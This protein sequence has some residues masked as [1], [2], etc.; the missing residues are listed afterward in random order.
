MKPNYTLITYQ[1][2]P[3]IKVS[4]EYNAAWN[5]K[6]QAVAGAKWSKTLNSWHI[7][8]T[9]EN[10]KKCGLT[11][12][13]SITII[14][15]QPGIKTSGTALSSISTNNKKQLEKFLQQ[16]ALKAYSPSTVRTYRN[17]FGTFLQTLGKHAAEK[18]TVQ[19]IKD[20]LQY[21]HTQLKLSENSIH[22]RMNAFYPVGLKK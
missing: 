16:L 14:K 4:F 13:N 22:S 15:Q 11:E 6:M 18:L 3:R 2:K 20:Y 9:A 1:N 10:R 12:N 7:P 8:D 5:K 19:R 17:E 21:C